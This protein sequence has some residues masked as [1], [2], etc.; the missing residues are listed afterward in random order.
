MNKTEAEEILNSLLGKTYQKLYE[1]NRKVMKKSEARRIISL[2]VRIDKRLG[3]SILDA[4]S[5]EGIL[6]IG[7]R[8]VKI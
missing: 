5:K 3:D 1:K 6:K 4:L 2:E 7:K 8:K